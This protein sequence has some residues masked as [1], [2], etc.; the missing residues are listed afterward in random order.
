MDNSYLQSNTNVIP[1]RWYC[2]WGVLCLYAVRCV[3]MH[4]SEVNVVF[5]WCSTDRAH[6]SIWCGA[7]Y[8]T[9]G[10]SWTLAQGLRGQV[11]QKALWLHLRRYLKA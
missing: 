8:E 4:T 7:L 2:K 11:L 1:H 5:L 10:A 9:S 6:S 3:C